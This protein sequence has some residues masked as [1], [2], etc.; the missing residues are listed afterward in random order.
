[1]RPLDAGPLEHEH[2]GRVAADHLVLE[3]G[4]ELVEPVRPLLDQRYLVT[5]AQKG[6]R[7]V[8]SDLAA[9]RD[10]EV[11]QPAGLSASRTAPTSVSI[12]ADVGQTIRRPRVA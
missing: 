11:H 10:H 12:A 5:A 2:L 9:A 6:T 8:R 4:L 3:L 1:G 7:E